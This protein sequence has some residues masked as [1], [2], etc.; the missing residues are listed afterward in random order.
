M[1]P[2]FSEFMQAFEGDRR[3]GWAEYVMFGDHPVPW[4]TLTDKQR[5]HYSRNLQNAPIARGRL[6]RTISLV[7]A[8]GDV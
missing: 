2:A 8:S 5:A 6:G 1:S 3:E 4:P 7:G